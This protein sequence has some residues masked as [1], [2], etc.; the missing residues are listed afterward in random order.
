MTTIE[1]TVTEAVAR[2]LRILAGIVEDRAHHPDRSEILLLAF[3]MKMAATSAT[4]TPIEDGRRLP[5]YTLNE[6]QEARDLMEAHDFHLSPAVLDY[7]VAPA[8]GDVGPMEPLGAVSQKLARDDFELQKRRNTVIRGRRLDSDDDEAV[9]W[10]LRAL[11]AIHYSHERLAKVVAVD[12]ARP[13]NQGKT[14]FHLT[15]Q[16]RYARKAAATAGPTDG[17]KLVAALKEFGIPAFLVRDD[18]GI[19]YVLVAV[20]RSTGE[21]EAH[22]GPKVYLYSGENADVDPAEHTEPWVAALYD[23]DSDY[24][25][26]LFVTPAG[27]DLAAEC[28]EAALMLAAWLDVNADRHPRT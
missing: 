17:D 16:Q 18:G 24:V 5:V 2:R 1:T 13:C 6:L 3:K 20:D 4:I 22:T 21:G 15:M 8:L 19:S 7:A 11:T 14:P 28:A 27:L 23:A 26:E 12:N 25:D 10:A 9:A